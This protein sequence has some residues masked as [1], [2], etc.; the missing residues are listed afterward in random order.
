MMSMSLSHD[1][2][3][4][5]VKHIFRLPNQMHGQLFV[6]YINKQGNEE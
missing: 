2:I 5:I 3:Y 6:P 1:M 4:V